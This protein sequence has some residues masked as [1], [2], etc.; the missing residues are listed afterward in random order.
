MGLKSESA[1]DRLPPKIRSRL[2]DL[3]PQIVFQAAQGDAPAGESK[4]LVTVRAQQRIVTLKEA[5]TTRGRAVCQFG[6]CTYGEPARDF[7]PC[8]HMVQV[9]IHKNMDESLLVPHD[10]T[11]GMWKR[12]YPFNI[13]LEFYM[14]TREQFL[15]RDPSL[16]DEN[17]GLPVTAP[18]KSDPLR[19][20]VSVTRRKLR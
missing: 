18:T 9:E 7:F 20:S 3:N 19:R 2:R 4:F 15:T 1:T 5:V 8:R 11:T 12:Q 6:G 17:L 10:L 13:E 14:P 16:R